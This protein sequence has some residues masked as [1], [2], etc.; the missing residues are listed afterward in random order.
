MA[1]S[2]GTNKPEQIN[3]AN[4][5]LE[6]LVQIKQEFEQVS[7]VAM[8]EQNYFYSRF[9]NDLWS[10]LGN[11]WHPR[12]PANIVRLQSQICQFQGSTRI[13]PTRME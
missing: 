12:V 5:S 3:L 1:S 2:E 9:M 4:L 13:I 7:G 11:Q 6:Q 8:S 10:V